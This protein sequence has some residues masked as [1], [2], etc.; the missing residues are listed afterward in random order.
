MIPNFTTLPEPA[1]PVFD[2]AAI[3]LQ[4]RMRFNPLRMLDP[5]RLSQALDQFDTGLLSPAALLW[6]AMCR[7]DDTLSFLK[8][9]LEETI[10][11]QPWGV[12]ARAGADPREA[13]RHKVALEWF[14]EH[15]QATDA[16]DR[17]RRGGRHLL[18][19]QMMTSASFAY[20]VHHFVW[21]PRPGTLLPVA[22]AE[23]VPAL[24]AELELVPLWYFENTTGTL[25]FLPQGGFS[26]PGQPL[27]WENEWMVTC[28]EGL[29]FAGSICYTFKRLTFQDWTI[30][31]ERYGQG[32]VVA[33]TPAREDTAQ[34]AGDG[35]HRGEFQ[36][37]PGDRAL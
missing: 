4:R 31:N 11:A 36:R 14:Y 37:R 26:L 22:G 15:V 13:A 9:Q 12:H 17:N 6:D 19:K 3:E 32:K 1:A 5:D 35:F 10:A 8:P 18:L 7:R 23:P 21:Q 30:Y 16:Y 33:Q 25:R 28:G 20:A 34:G 2:P 24:S 27:D 29:M